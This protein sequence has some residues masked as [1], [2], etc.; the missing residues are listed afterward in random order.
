MKFLYFTPI[1]V[2]SLF[3]LMANNNEG[4]A[5]TI[6]RSSIDTKYTWKLEDIYASDD[7][8]Q[9]AKEKV[10]SQ[11]DNFD[12]FKG[13]L[14]SS[15]KI[16]LEYLNFSSNFDKELTR[17]HSYA[18][19]KSDQDI[20]ESKYLAMKQELTQLMPVVG[21]KV[22]F[23]E[24]EILEMGKEKIDQ[25]IAQ[26]LG[27]AQYKHYL[28]DLLRNKEHTLSEKE[29]K[30]LA[31]AS[32][33]MGSPHSI[34]NIF[35]NA[36]LPYPQVKLSDG[37]TV[38]I[39][40]AGFAKYRTLTDKD[41]REKVF[42][43]FY[44][45]L[46]GFQRTL[47]EQLFS[48]VNADIFA[49]RARNFNSSLECALNRYN[50]P[51][52]VYHSL[53]DNVNKNLP[54]FHRYLALRK[55][56]LGLDT[57]K[58]S[59]MYIPVVKDIKLE[60]KFE[61]AKGLILTA[62]KPLGSEYQETLNRAFNERWLD[63]YPT[64]GK[65]SGAYSNGS[66]Y[67]IHPYILLNYNNMYNDVSTTA[68]E[69]GHTLHSFLSNK[70][71]PYPTSNYSIFVAEVAST[72]NEALL[73]NYM[74]KSISDDNVKLSLLMNRLD[75]FKATLFRQTQ[76]AEFELAIHEKAEAGEA[77]NSEALCKIYGDILR[78]YYG[79]DKG[80]CKVDA[81][82]S[83]E[84]SYV[85]H[86]Y[87]NFYVYQY[88]TSFTASAALAEKV[89]SNEKGSVDKYLKFLSSGCSDYPIELLKNAGVDMTSNEPFDKA[90]R[91]M[92]KIMDEIETILKKQGK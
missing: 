34:F 3:S 55:R 18:S 10:K 27:L 82:Y 70:N 15:A 36:E 2:L 89:L 90:I 75:N 61:E 1:L 39:N 88:A 57:L 41:D 72:F 26:E 13:K 25:F 53:I 74:V 37:K 85:P 38:T 60:Y 22:A 58:Y 73:D 32:S 8:W 69:L 54:T 67:D 33:V 40:Q 92:N 62:M 71:Q 47:A 16:L 51:V 48:N 66:V 11:I 59:D 86:F 79:A 45:A 52:S 50:I 83:L 81:L 64:A 56:M 17:I 35:T 84:W 21:A 43:S 42:K 19:M 28:Y 49:A 7:D 77:L 12:T 91:S 23:A 31:Q 44:N 4:S 63:V 76:F 30:I 14:G 65:R 68:H 20:R 29:E 6:E 78:K 80:V 5:Q 9:K 46:G 87:Y 24:P